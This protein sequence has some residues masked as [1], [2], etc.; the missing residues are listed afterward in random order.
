MTRIGD[1]TV[2]SFNHGRTSAI[3]TTAVSLT[4]TSMLAAKGVQVRAADSNTATVYLG[5]SD[6]TADTADQTDGF[7]LA[8]GEALFVP[9]N[10]A[11]KVF[12]RSTVAGQ[13]VF[14]FAI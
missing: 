9:V 5:N 10:D 2:N 3:G 11:Q 4:D 13:K 14:W 12:V 8:A 6:L 1:E 7:P